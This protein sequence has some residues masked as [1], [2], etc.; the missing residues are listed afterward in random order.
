[1]DLKHIY[2]TASLFEQKKRRLI[3]EVVVK[4]IDKNVYAKAK[5]TN[6]IL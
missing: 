3:F 4:D 6:W 2:V 5:I 1:M